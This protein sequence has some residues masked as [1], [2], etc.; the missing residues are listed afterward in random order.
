[1]KAS[2]TKTI[3]GVPATG[4]ACNMNAAL[5]VAMG[6]QFWLGMLAFTLIHIAMMLVTRKGAK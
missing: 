3:C 4:F 1:M 5:I 6:G 2:P